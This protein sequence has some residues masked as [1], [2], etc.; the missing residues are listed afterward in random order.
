MLHLFIPFFDQ[1]CMSNKKALLT[2]LIISVGLI[3]CYFIFN[4]LFLLILALLIGL[5]GLISLKARMVIVN[6]WIRLGKALGYV[7]SRI[8]LSV[9]YFFILT[10]IAL[11][12]RI[13]SKDKLQ[14]KRKNSDESYFIKRDHEFQAQD[15]EN[16]W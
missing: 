8:I 14:L 10:P 6:T 13:F 16:P 3:G 11:L 2:V 12:S 1:P 15:F 9:I 4:K 7:N 5:V